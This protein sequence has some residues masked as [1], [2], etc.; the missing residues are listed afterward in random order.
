MRFFILKRKTFHTYTKKEEHAHAHFT[1]ARVFTHLLLSSSSSKERDP[2]RSPRDLSLLP[3]RSRESVEKRETFLSFFL[4]VNFC[5]VIREKGKR[6]LK[7]AFH[8]GA[9]P[10][11]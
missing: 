11:V 5:C 6:D 9:Q 8:V 3:S 4:L 2:L 1:C 10:V 7:N